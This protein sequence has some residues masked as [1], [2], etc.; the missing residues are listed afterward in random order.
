MLFERDP[1]GLR[2]GL[3]NLTLTVVWIWPN[4]LWIA[5]VSREYLGVDVQL[6][7]VHAFLTAY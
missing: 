2:L 4:G 7:G 5:C 3:V 1:A 6:R